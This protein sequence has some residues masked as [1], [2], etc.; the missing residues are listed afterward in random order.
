MPR[1]VCLAIIMVTLL[2][3]ALVGI[4]ADARTQ[5]HNHDRNNNMRVFVGGGGGFANKRSP[6]VLPRATARSSQPG[7]VAATPPMGWNSWNYYGCGV[8]ASVLISTAQVMNQS[9]LL[10]AGYEQVN[11][12]DCWMLQQRAANGTWI[13]NPAT[14]PGGWRPVV[15]QIKSLGMKTGL[16]TARGFRTCQGRAASCEREAVDANFIC[17]NGL[18]Y[19]KDDACSTCRGDRDDENYGAMWRALQRTSCAGRITLTVEG[20]PSVLAMSAGGYGNARRVGHDIN[21]HFQSMLTLV[22]IGSGLWPYAHN[23]SVSPIRAGYWNDLD[24]LETGNAPDFVCSRSPAALERCRYH[25]SMWSISK[26]VLLLGNNMQTLDNVT[27]GVVTNKNAI[28]VNQDSLGI[29]GRR[30]AVHPPRNQT[31]LRDRSFA[32]IKQCNSSRPTQTWTFTPATSRHNLARFTFLAP[33]DATDPLQ[34]WRLDNDR[35]FNVGANECFDPARSSDPASLAPCTTASSSSQQYWVYD[36]SSRHIH[37]R[38]G[39]QCLDV[40]NFESSGPVE[41]YPCKGAGDSDSNQ[42][43][44]QLPGGL[45]SPDSN[46]GQCVKARRP[47]AGAGSLWTTDPTTQA[48]VCLSIGGAGFMQ[49]R[50]CDP[51]LVNPVTELY[52]FVDGE[53]LGVCLSESSL[54]TM[55]VHAN[56]Q[57]GASGPVPHSRYLTRTVGG[58][59]FHV[60]VRKL[61]ASGGGRIRAGDIFEIIN[62]DLVG[63][64]TRG[65][66]FCLDA[67]SGML[68]VWATPLQ[69]GRIAVVCANRSPGVDHIT[70]TAAQVG[71]EASQSYEMFDIWQDAYIQDFENGVATLTVQPFAVRYVVLSPV[72]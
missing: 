64:V 72:N 11:S 4:F 5:Q 35:L 45:L 26:A 57:I 43:F 28:A 71:A 56:T 20:N 41:I 62:D 38:D 7:D 1:C 21:A 19:V 17:D 61:T 65:G 15:A 66:E 59:L 8:S 2:L 54:C 33:C 51:K 70:F 30:V 34:Q 52:E 14:F 13:P 42:R 68:E 46:K 58:T 10:A 48:P 53:T 55:G 25:F 37:N 40:Y 50:P 3:L 27:L 44:S 60:D 29:Q 63:G 47:A 12:D 69:G 22:D 23:A 6:L 9:G 31:L 67:V 39:S 32:V 36:N 16:Y 24:M 49:L 18:T